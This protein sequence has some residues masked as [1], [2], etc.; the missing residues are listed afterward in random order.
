MPNIRLETLNFPQVAGLRNGVQTW[1]LAWPE[2]VWAAVSVGKG[3]LAHVIQHGQYSMFEIVYRAAMIYANLLETPEGRFGRSDAYQGLD[4]SEKGAVSYFMGLVLTKAF[5]A[6]K[7]GVPWLMHMDLYRG[8]FNVNLMPGE[9]PD[10]FGQ[11]YRGRWIVAESKG[12]THGHSSEA[13][14]KA[15]AQAAQVVDIGGVRPHLSIGLVASFN[16]GCL[17]L[18]ADDPPVDRSEGRLKVQLSPEEFRETYYRP[19]RQLFDSFE[20][21]ELDLNDY[22]IRAVRSG[23]ADLMVGISERRIQE[24]AR[25]RFEP[26]R[27]VQPIFDEDGESF[28]GIDGVYVRL[29]KSW[30]DERM[31]LQPQER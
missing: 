14:T 9:R 21:Y 22:D 1:G 29:G 4:P 16:K 17:S 6:Q 11:D 27:P 15:K 28:L 24:V 20:T 3:S 25:R 8:R 31:Q 12:R 2:L 26:D 19:F 18:I 5:A 7:L 30:R 10:L 13:L 23:S